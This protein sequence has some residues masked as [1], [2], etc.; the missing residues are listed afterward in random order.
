MS[1]VTTS[2]S[3]SSFFGLRVVPLLLSPSSETRKK[4]ARKKNIHARSWGRE[5]RAAIFFSR[6]SSASFSLDG[7]SERG[8]T[9]SLL[10]FQLPM[11]SNH[12]G[13]TG[14]KSVFEMLRFRGPACARARAE[15]TVDGRNEAAS[16]ASCG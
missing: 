3:K 5:A 11:F 2:F 12:A 10:L 6:F 14:L 4:P 16:L 8:T 9:R 15:F 7:L 13:L 1:I